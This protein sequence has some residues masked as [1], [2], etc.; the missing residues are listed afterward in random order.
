MKCNVTA[1]LLCNL[2]GATQTFKMELTV[3]SEVSVCMYELIQHCIPE[4]LKLHHHWYENLKF[5]L[6]VTGS[7]WMSAEEQGMRTLC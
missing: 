5:C 1:L 2:S 3:F 7:H 4:V 6:H